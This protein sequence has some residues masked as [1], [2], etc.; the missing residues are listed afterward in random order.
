[1]R[2]VAWGR[3]DG[4]ARDYNE[5]LMDE[6]QKG[7]WILNS[8]KHLSQVQT[9]VPELSYFEATEQSGKAG[10][11]LGRLLADAQEIV[12]GAKVKV[13]ARES[14]ITAGELMPCLRHLKAEGKVDFTVDSSGAVKSVEVYSFSSKDAIET[15]A[16]L[17]DRLGPSEHEQASLV[18][19]DQTFHLPHYR[20][21]LIEKLT[22][23]GYREPIAASTVD[24]QDTLQ[25]VRT[26]KETGDALFY[27]EYAF[28]SG[29]Q[30]VA[31]ALKSLS[32]GE[33]GSVQEIQGTLEAAPGYPL[34]ALK[35]KYPGHIIQLME[36]VG[37]VDAVTVNSEFGEATFLTLPQLRGSSIASSLLSTDVF[38]KA[39]VLL[40][41]LRFGELKSVYSRGKIDTNDKMMNIVNKL[42]RGEWVGPCTAIG[43]DYQLLEKDGVIETEPARGGMYFMKLR[44]RE[45]GL[46]VRQMLEMKQVIPEIDIDL[47]RLL[48]NQPT[49]YTIP[50]HRRTRIQAVQVKGVRTIREKILQSLRTGVKL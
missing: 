12:P 16:R 1:L 37:L 43:Q 28:A 8:I 31:R 27:N 50:E 33:R 19:L 47:Q 5:V 39:K 23:A 9:N 34:D 10:M 45:V 7:T 3:G 44:Q 36:G 49:S 42:I 2:L 24:M 26:S 22:K 11:L 40:S 35:R 46:L 18:S 21:E 38:H 20:S 6:L 32:D 29:P 41:C 25:L 4:T 48:E 13:F 15:T 30:K 17:Y 14:G